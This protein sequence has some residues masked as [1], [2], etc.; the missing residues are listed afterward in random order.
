[1]FYN[2]QIFDPSTGFGNKWYSIT[3]ENSLFKS[4]TG[5]LAGAIYSPNIYFVSSNKYN[6]GQIIRL[7]CFFCSPAGA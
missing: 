4:N 6:H 2:Y 5:N 1:M 3:V 7:P